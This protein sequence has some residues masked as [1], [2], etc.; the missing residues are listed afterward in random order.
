M[1]FCLNQPV[2][3]DYSL[4]KHKVTDM[5]EFI[6]VNNWLPVVYFIKITENDRIETLKV[7]VN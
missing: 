7:V 1:L 3:V 2:C 4:L 6:S 5:E